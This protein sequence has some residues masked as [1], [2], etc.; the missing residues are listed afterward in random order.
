MPHNVASE[1]TVEQQL[2]GVKVHGLGNFAFLHRHHVGTTG[3]S[4]STINVL[5]QALQKIGPERLGRVLYLQLDNCSGD[6]KNRFVLM[7]CAYL[8]H[9]GLFEKVK[10][11][12]LCVGHTHE[13]IDQLFSTYV[14]YL[15]RYGALGLRSPPPSPSPPMPLLL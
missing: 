10:I 7:F 6:N 5:L 13:D 2:I 15:R 14:S 12:F 3:G 1:Y 11:S 9:I 4:N 8:V